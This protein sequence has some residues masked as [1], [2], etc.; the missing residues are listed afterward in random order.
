VLMN[1]NHTVA[2]LYDGS[3]SPNSCE[4]TVYGSGV[5]TLP[6][7]LDVFAIHNASDGSLGVVTI[8][9]TIAGPGVLN[10]TGEGQL[11]LH[12]SNTWTG[13][14]SL[15]NSQRAWEGTLYFDT[16]NA[17]GLGSIY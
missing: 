14:T 5:M 10:L 11:Y 7:G 9:N 3:L 4:V 15:G 2:A 13:G 1:S 6:S 12:G 17:F 16:A 8:S